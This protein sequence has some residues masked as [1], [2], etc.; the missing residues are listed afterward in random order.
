MVGCGI[1]VSNCSP[2]S[3]SCLT[4][5]CCLN[6]ITIVI[7]RLGHLGMHRPSEPRHISIDHSQA[8]ISPGQWSAKELTFENMCH[9]GL[10]HITSLLAVNGMG[11]SLWL[12]ASLTGLWCMGMAKRGLLM[13]WLESDWWQAQSQAATGSSLS[14]KLLAGLELWNAMLAFELLNAALPSVLCL[15]GCLLLLARG[16]GGGGGAA[17]AAGSGSAARR[18]ARR[19]RRADGRSSSTRNIC[20]LWVD[21]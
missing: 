21:V 10:W 2:D 6:T 5:V 19:A 18:G 16:G 3:A 14:Q 9:W 4:K 11:T 17:A 1:S 12:M 13:V 15:E 8:H 7:W 20:D